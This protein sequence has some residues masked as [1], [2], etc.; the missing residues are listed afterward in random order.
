MLAAG[1]IFPVDKSD[2]I[3]PIVIQIKKQTY[4]IQVC[5][6][7]RSFNSAAT[8]SLGV[9]AC[10]ESDNGPNIPAEGNRMKR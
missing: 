3:S 8:P 4:Y 1:L 10:P 5:V 2:W 9:G 6:D 7:F